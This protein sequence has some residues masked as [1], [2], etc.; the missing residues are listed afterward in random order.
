MFNTYSSWIDDASQ[1]DPGPGVPWALIEGVSALVPAT[2]VSFHEFDFL[3]LTSIAYQSLTDGKRTEAVNEV[4]GSDVEEWLLHF[5]RSHCSYPQRSGDLRV[6]L[7]DTDFMS[8]L[9]W[10]QSPQYIDVVAEEGFL[11][12]V[13]VSLPALPGRFR[14]LVLARDRDVPFS[15]RDRRLLGLLRPHL[16]EIWLDAQHRRAGPPRLTPREWEVLHLVGAGLSNVDIATYLVISVSTVR[17][18]LENAYDRL[19]VRTRT[20]AAA[21]A[22][23]FASKI[24]P[25]Q[26]ATPSLPGSSRRPVPR[27]R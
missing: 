11:H 18:H 16:N 19:G 27:P 6:V 25:S 20:A 22:L 5:W 21:T 17:K 14:R 3:N 15:E 4:G 1:D 24:V 10:R 26:T 23:P 7:L 2:L 13:V 12:D 9:Q 8:Q